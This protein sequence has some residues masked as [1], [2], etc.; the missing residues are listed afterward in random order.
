MYKDIT[1]DSVNIKTKSFYLK[2]RIIPLKLIEIVDSIIS[3]SFG[4]GIRIMYKE[5]YKIKMNMFF[6][7]FK[8][9]DKFLI[10]FFK[11]LPK[12]A[13]VVGFADEES[14]ALKYLDKYQIK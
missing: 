5:D 1:I 10:E 7:D 2:E 6:L 8:D 13:V 12:S 9:D 3:L 4:T 14:E 11:R